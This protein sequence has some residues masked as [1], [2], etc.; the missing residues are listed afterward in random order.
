M[1]FDEWKN[2]GRYFQH[3]EHAIFHHVHGRGSTALVLIHGFPTASWDWVPL[4]PA[5]T[6]K[7]A[8]VIAI[9]APLTQMPER[10]GWAGSP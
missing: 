7:F 3:G 8:H 6:Q 4:W 10:F 9:D 2:S 1:T 5:L